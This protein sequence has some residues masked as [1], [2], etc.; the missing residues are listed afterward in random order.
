MVLIQA[1]C[2]QVCLIFLC[3]QTHSELVPYGSVNRNK[4]SIRQLPLYFLSHHMF[5][6]LL[7]IFR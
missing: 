6:P 4:V 7:A 5:R 3:R 1:I 2:T